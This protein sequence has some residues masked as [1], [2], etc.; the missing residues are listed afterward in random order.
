MHFDKG[1]KL[2][3]LTKTKPEGQTGQRSRPAAFWK[4]VI[5]TPSTAYL[6]L[7]IEDYTTPST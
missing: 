4:F 3:Y 1:S 6:C 7:N 5:L 2:Q